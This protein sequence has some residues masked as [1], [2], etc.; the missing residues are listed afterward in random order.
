[1]RWIACICIMAALGSCKEELSFIAG[2]GALPDCNDTPID[3]KGKYWFNDDGPVTIRTDGC[4]DA[5][6]EDMFTS[7]AENWVLTQDGN[8][9]SIVVDE[10]RINGR[11]CGDQ[12]HLEGGW[13][14]SVKD[15]QGHCWYEDDDGDD[16]SIEKDGNVLTFTP[17]DDPNDDTMTGL[18]VL[19]GSCDVDYEVTLRRTSEPSF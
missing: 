5:V 1:M 4:L 11:L 15:D 9:V 8:D 2:T 13:W 3:L 6:P 12:L 10:Y 19:K 14:L 7:C 18:L 17:A 16:M